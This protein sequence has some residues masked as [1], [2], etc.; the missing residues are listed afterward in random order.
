M[1]KPFRKATENT[2]RPGT[3]KTS[4]EASSPS[5]SSSPFVPFSNLSELLLL[6]V[7]D[8]QSLPECFKNLTSLIV[9]GIARCPSLKFLSPGIQHLASSLQRLDIDGCRQLDMSD[10]D[11][12]AMKSSLLKL[13][14][15]N[16]PQLETLPLGLQHVTSLQHLEVRECEYLIE[17]PEWISNFKSLHTLRI[18]ECPNLTSL[19][20]GIRQLTS[21]H[22]LEIEDCPILYKRCQRESGEDWPKLAHIPEFILTSSSTEPSTASSGTFT[23]P[24]SFLNFLFYFI[25]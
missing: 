3:Q 19:P 17:I 22:K 25:S 5:H 4:G 20:Q 9:L 23:N 13:C 11:G 24:P 7:K 15:T 18:L 16:L 21:V 2:A 10:T 8:L 6:H 14:L 12:F 1:W